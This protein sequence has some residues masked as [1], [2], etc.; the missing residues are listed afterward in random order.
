MFN[1]LK[2]KDTITSVLAVDDRHVAFCEYNGE[3]N[4]C[5]SSHTGEQKTFRACI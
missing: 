3:D 2:D 1:K 4:L 5:S